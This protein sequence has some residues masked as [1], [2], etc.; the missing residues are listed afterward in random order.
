MY[1]LKQFLFQKMYNALYQHIREIIASI[2]LN[3][4][5]NMMYGFAHTVVL[6]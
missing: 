3:E 4:N 6:C 1:V 5:A 2:Q